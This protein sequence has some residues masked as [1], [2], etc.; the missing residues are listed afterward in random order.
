MPRWRT[1]IEP[2]ETSWPS[3]ALTPRRWPTLSRPFLELEPAFLCA[4]SVTRPSWCVRALGVAWLR[5]ASALVGVAGRRALRW[6]ACRPSVSVAFDAVGLG[7]RSPASSACA[8][9]SP[10]WLGLGGLGL[11]GLRL[12]PRPRS[13]RRPRP[14]WRR[15][16]GRRRPCVGLLL[17]GLARL[18]LLLRLGRRPPR[19]R[20]GR[21]S[22]CPRR[23]GRSAPGGGP[24]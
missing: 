2:A 14:A 23:A 3:P 5:S 17:G 8:P 24:S 9:P 1:M 21:R 6:P 13:W 4:T 15:A 7:C 16:P 12:G 18:A 11:G 19:R 20:C 22:G 10:W